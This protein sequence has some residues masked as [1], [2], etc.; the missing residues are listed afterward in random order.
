MRVD[1]VILSSNF[2]P[3]YY[4]FWN[5]LSKLWKVN[6]KIQPT[7]IWVGT[8]E[9]KEKAHLN[10]D[11]GD[12]IVVDEEISYPI[13]WVTTWSLFYHTK[14]FQH[15][16][17]LIMGI[18]QIPTS[19]YFINEKIK[20]IDGNS[21]VMLLDD[22]Y[23]GKGKSGCW[24]SPGGCCPSA[25]HIS[26]G[27][28]FNEVYG[29]E[30]NF[31][32]ELKKLNETHTIV[33]MYQNSQNKWGMDESY[34]SEKLR[35]YHNKGGKIDALSL[36]YELSPNRRIEC[37]RNKEVGYDLKKLQ[38]GFYVESH[39][40]RPYKNHK[41]YIDNLIKNIKIYNYE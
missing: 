2:N 36:A 15:E 25:Y 14:F 10:E 31:I 1:R 35:E 12:I 38:E 24:K 8:E 23:C 22:A 5:P 37:F 29:F 32:E 39:I 33:K 28:T 19:D 6:F 41:N 9:E 3:T 13:P 4:D 18:D 16:T 21:Y 40:C 11:Y 20:S 30:S 26:K 7:L 27:S 17:C 34:S